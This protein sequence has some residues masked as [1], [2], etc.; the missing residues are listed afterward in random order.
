MS[1]APLLSVV[2]PTFN[3]AEL[4]CR[5]LETVK[6]QEFTDFET[7]V[8]DDGSTD[9][10]PEHLAT[11]GDRLTVVRQENAGPAAARNAGIARARGRY[12][13][14]LD[15]DD[16]WFPWTLATFARAIETTR[17]PSFLCGQLQPFTDEAELVDVR[18]EELSLER[19]DDY[20][21]S[22]HK[23]Y[24]VGSGM[25]VY[26][27]DALIRAGSFDTNL[28]N[29]EDHDLSLRLGTAPGFVKINRPITL[30]YRR[31][32]GSIQTVSR[33]AD[34]LRTCVARERAH[35]YPG[36]RA[37]ARERRR[38]LSLHARPLSLACL[39]AR[40]TD[41]ALRIYADTLTWNLR[42]GRV[43]YV[44]GFPAKCLKVCA[45]QRSE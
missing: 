41:L 29:M 37:R 1:A 2:I 26:S 19:F 27:R 22:S 21:A 8:V 39:D 43:R 23:A 40:R 42:Q 7:I 10:T 18:D 9:S 13:C 38:L 6:A 16:L 35:A 12:V 15:S 17:G 14:M 20:L 3:R 32:A 44:L 4:L 45:S 30:A 24:F 28:L 5:A 11:Y 25:A 31:H 34:A 33:A 36:G